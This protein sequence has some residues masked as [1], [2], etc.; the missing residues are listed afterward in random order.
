[1]L[2]R[3]RTPL[4]IS[5]RMMCGL[6]PWRAGDTDHCRPQNF[7]VKHVSRLQLSNNNPIGVLGRLNPRNCVVVMRVELLSEGLDAHEALLRQRLPQLPPNQLETFAIFDVRRV[8]RIRE[9][10]IECVEHR[11]QVFDDRF[12]GAM[13]VV[14][15]LLFDSLAVVFKIRLPPDKRVGQ[16]LLLSS[17]LLHLLG[18]SRRV[19]FG[20]RA[21]IFR[22]GRIDRL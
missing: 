6:L 20:H 8:G 1:M 18:E 2:L 21:L 15:P 7:V 12:R 10:A 3:R 13:S 17:K 19:S 22:R 4:I 11:K 14:M 16:L 5:R 9:R